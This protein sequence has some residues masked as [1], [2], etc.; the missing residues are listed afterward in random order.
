MSWRTSQGLNSSEQPVQEKPA[1]SRKAVDRC[2][3]RRY[4]ET[5]G[6]CAQLSA[7]E[8]VA[9]VLMAS[10]PAAVGGFLRPLRTIYHP[11]RPFEAQEKRREENN[12]AQNR[13]MEPKYTHV[14][15]WI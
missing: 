4:E 10:R 3:A 15:R 2:A 9:G 5:R 8:S 11:R 6:G 1:K 7:S 14:T 12:A 13:G